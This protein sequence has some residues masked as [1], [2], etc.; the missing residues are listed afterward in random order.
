MKKLVLLVLGFILGAV[1]TYYF[2][3]RPLQEEVA[4]QKIVKP[5]GLITFDEAK[6]L[7]DNWSKY[8]QKAVDSASKKYGGRNKDTRNVNWP[9]E[10]VENY[11]AYA[12]SQADSLGYEVTG[13][14]VYL[15]VYGKNQGQAKKNLSTMFIVPT[16][17]KTT[18]KA[19]SLNFNLQG[20]PT[21]LDVSPL[22]KVTGGTGDFPQ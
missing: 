8:R 21:D 6:V 9:L 19:S 12:K 5:K 14:R 13:L 4:E 16:G 11:I 1:I 10:E 20:G 17:T 18:S 15:G 22:N 7:N 2:C 3:P